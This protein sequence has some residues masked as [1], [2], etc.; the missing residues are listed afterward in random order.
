MTEKRLTDL[1]FET[2]CNRDFFS[3]PAAWEDQ[4]LY[5]LMLDRF[6]DGNEN[7][8]IDNDGNPVTSGNTPLYGND[9]SGNATITSEDRKR[10]FN[11]GGKFVSGTLKGLESKIGY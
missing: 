7:G 1:G 5:F 3:S 6:S 4:V 10:W 8:Y 9:D 11:A 2:L